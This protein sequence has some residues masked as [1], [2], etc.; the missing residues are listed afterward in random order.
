MKWFIRQ[1]VDGNL[2]TFNKLMNQG[3][4]CDMKSLTVCTIRRYVRLA[5]AYLLAYEK[6]LDIVA[7]E[8]QL[9]KHLFRRGSRQQIDSVL[10]KLY[11]PCRRIASNV[12]VDII[13]NYG[14]VVETMLLKGATVNGV[15]HKNAVDHYASHVYGDDDTHEYEE[16]YDNRA[17]VNAGV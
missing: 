13:E 8:E 5:R 7:A 16:W 2:Q 9:K 1:L 6:G 4:T 17:D 10:E 15:L 11:L 3:L 12:K 14:D